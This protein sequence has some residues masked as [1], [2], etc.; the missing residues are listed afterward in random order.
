VLGIGFTAALL[1]VSLGPLAAAAALAALGG[2]ASTVAA[3]FVPLSR[4]RRLTAPTVLA[5]E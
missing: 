2:T 4:L 5:A 1:S 3:S